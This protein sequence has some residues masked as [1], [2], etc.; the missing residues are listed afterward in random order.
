LEFGSS[1]ASTLDGLHEALVLVVTLHS[2][3]VD[4][5][6]LSEE[7]SLITLVLVGDNLLLISAEAEHLAL[8]VSGKSLVSGSASKDLSLEDRE[9]RVVL[10]GHS[11]VADAG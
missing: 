5:G 3:V 7:G 6:D 8:V 9:N 2:W 4:V 11:T 1:V 10:V